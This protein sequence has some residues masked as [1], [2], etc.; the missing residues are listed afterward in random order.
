LVSDED[1]R[2]DS[3]PWLGSLVRQQTDGTEIHDEEKLSSFHL[4]EKL[5]RPYH[6][7]VKETT[8]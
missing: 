4:F 2:G 5:I 7:K 1:G 6:P 3:A 8:S